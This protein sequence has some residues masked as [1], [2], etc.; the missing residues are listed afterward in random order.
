VIRL[1]GVLE[2]LLDV[3]AEPVD[4]PEPPSWCRKRGWTEFLLALDER[5]LE[6][7]E[8]N[9]LESAALDSAETPADFRELFRE[10]RQ[11]C[12]L[13][14]VE[15]GSL[16]LPP[17]ALRGVPARKR[18]QLGT[19]LAVLTPLA[20]RAQRVVDVGAGSGHFSRLSAELFGRAA[21]ALDRNAALLERGSALRAERSR[22]VG[23]LDVEFVE[24][25]LARQELALKATDLAVGLHACGGLGVRRWRKR[26]ALSR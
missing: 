9:G 5:A 16:S 19:L 10:V 4:E 1:L 18:E 21:L 11:L 3:V 15:M 23:T 17:A 22:D 14:R 20:T 7:W 8:S 13:E 2:P 26:P 24:V 6:D 12:R 25:D